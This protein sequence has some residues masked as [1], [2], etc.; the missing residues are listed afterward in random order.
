M[1]T[2]SSER[3]GVSSKSPGL[4]GASSSRSDKESSK[5]RVTRYSLESAGHELFD[6]GLFGSGE[7]TE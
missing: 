7:G 4:G 3:D 1:G 6:L 2:S 5:S